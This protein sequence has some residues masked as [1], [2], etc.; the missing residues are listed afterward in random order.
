MGGAGAAMVG[1]ALG[2][3]GRA[4]AMAAAV[5]P[6][7]VTVGAAM[8]AEVGRAAAT[9]AAAEVDPAV[10]TAGAAAAAGAATNPDLIAFS[11]IQCA[12]RP[13]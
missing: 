6:A 9:V 1:P 12:G 2:L 3:A 11:V 13:R 8:A 5:D 7:A 4:E 10:A